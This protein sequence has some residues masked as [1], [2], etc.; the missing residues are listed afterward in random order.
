MGTAVLGGVGFALFSLATNALAFGVFIALAAALLADIVMSHRV[1][2]P[3]KIAIVALKSRSSTL[4]GLT[5][6]AVPIAG[7]FEGLE[8]AVGT[9]GTV[10]RA[11]FQHI[12]TLA[13]Q[14]TFKLGRTASPRFVPFTLRHSSLGLITA[15]K[16]FVQ[17]T[18]TR[19]A[20]IGA[21]HDGEM[22][23]K[24]SRRSVELERLREYV[25][26]DRPN[27]VHWMA[28]A[29]TGQL[30]VRDDLWQQDEM[31]IV[32]QVDKK[33]PLDV[34]RPNTDFIMGLARLAIERGWDAGFLV[35]VITFHESNDTS[36][37]LA[38]K[39]A[40]AVDKAMP[41]SDFAGRP[42][43]TLRNEYV[44]DESELV[45][46][47]SGVFPAVVPRPNGPHYV[48]SREGLWLAE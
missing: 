19:M 18:P 41:Q 45:E 44:S 2:A 27:H 38:E 6:R 36:L 1:I 46:R 7:A 26:G 33:Q 24:A 8:I 35:R 17:I 3:T 5:V 11:Q 31:V 28:S 15:A 42:A 23:A 21:I 10:Q 9:L 48:I 39:A 12:E 14:L 13:N 16:G 37:A 4:D 29:K 25:P 22:E 43:A 40:L 47:L 34:E 30:Q 32:I 20:A